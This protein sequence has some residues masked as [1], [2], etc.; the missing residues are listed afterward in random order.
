MIEAFTRRHTPKKLQKNMT[1][2]EQLGAKAKVQGQ[3]PLFAEDEDDA[4]GAAQKSDEDDDMVKV[5]GETLQN[6]FDDEAVARN[7]QEEEYVAPPS[8]DPPDISIQLAV[9]ESQREAARRRDEE[10]LALIRALQASKSDA[11]LQFVAGAKEPS[12]A[13]TNTTASLAGDSDEDDFEEVEVPDANAI[14]IGD[15]DSTLVQEQPAHLDQPLE[16]SS[17]VIRAETPFDSEDEAMISAAIAQDQ[18]N[19]ARKA[20]ESV[21][22]VGE[23]TPTKS[24]VPLSAVKAVEETHT[25]PMDVVPFPVNDDQRRQ[26]S[27]GGVR[28][29][30]REGHAAFP[31]PSSTTAAPEKLESA[32]KVSRSTNAFV[33]PRKHLNV[34]MPTTHIQP[35]SKVDAFPRSEATISTLKTGKTTDTHD[36]GYNVPSPRNNEVSTNGLL[37]DPVLEATVDAAPA[38]GAAAQDNTGDTLESAKMRDANEREAESDDLDEDDLLDDSRSLEWSVSPEPERR[39][40]QTDTF[41]APPPDLEEDEGGIDMNAE[42]DDYARFL[43]EIKGRNLEQVRQEIDNEIRDLNQQN[44][45][46]MRDSED[47]THQMVAQIQVC[48][49]IW[50]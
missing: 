3:T 7:L 29:S 2:D 22:G 12:I 20:E 16:V 4:E 46:A 10:D 50:I 9:E 27:P 36:H 38:E 40:T 1:Y 23:R 18:A 13:A 44:K 25:S 5:I 30:S 11:R 35:Q 15:F 19:E 24:T 8:S 17:T 42:G 28:E 45:V 34:Q 41:P 32:A 43:A 47:I 49:P 21:P 14:E 48:S 39:Q 26:P 33:P 37:D 6:P 31:G